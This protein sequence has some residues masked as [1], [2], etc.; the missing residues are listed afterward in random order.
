[1]ATQGIR[2]HATFKVTGDKAKFAVLLEKLIKETRKEKGCLMY[3]Y[4]KQ[5]NEDTGMNFKHD[6]SLRNSMFS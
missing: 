1:M 2:A 5:Y 6:P 3:E 4:F